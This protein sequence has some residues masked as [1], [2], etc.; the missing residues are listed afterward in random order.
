[1]CPAPSY[2][3]IECDQAANW[4]INW[5][6]SAQSNDQFGVHLHVWCV[7]KRN[8]VFNAPTAGEAVWL[9]VSNWNDTGRPRTDSHV[10][11]RQRYTVIATGTMISFII[12]IPITTTTTS[13]VW[14]P[15]AHKSAVSVSLPMTFY[16]WHYGALVYTG[17]PACHNYT[18]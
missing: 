11:W 7:L 6:F 4:L 18:F 2:Q 5:G 14:M 10:R 17:F 12:N 16:H 8:V 3:F 13:N 15:F 1:M 9:C